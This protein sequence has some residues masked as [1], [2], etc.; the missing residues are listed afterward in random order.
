MSDS[1]ETALGEVPSDRYPPPPG[2]PPGVLRFGI[3]S[4]LGSTLVGVGVVVWFA[5]GSIA[6]DGDLTPAFDF[7]LNFGLTI[8]LIT[9]MVSVAPILAAIIAGLLARRMHALLARASVVAFAVALTA[10]GILAAFLQTPVDG[11]FWAQVI[12]LAAIAALGLAVSAVL[13]WRGGFASRRYDRV[14]SP[15]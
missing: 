15:R 12:P 7:A 8:P 11:V 14:A 2:L 4:V 5:S 9:A 13:P 10:G 3:V 6:L 1:A